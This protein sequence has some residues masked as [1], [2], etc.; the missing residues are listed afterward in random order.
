MSI[1]AQKLVNYAA[2]GI[3]NHQIAN[4]LGISEGRITQLLN[5]EKVANAIE[6]RKAAIAEE[7]VCEITDLK[8]VKRKII[9][10]LGELAENTES[11]SEAINALDKIDNITSR[12]IGS[13]DQSTGVKNIIIN[14]PQHVTQYVNDD[15]RVVTDSRNQITQIRGRSMAQMPTSG[16][17]QVLRNANE[18]SPSE[19]PAVTL[20]S[21]ITDDMLETEGAD[22]L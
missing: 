13:G 12:K 3:A 9:D 22:Q 2:H 10:R 6:K 17:I 19:D 1:D 5:A 15:A 20:I 7:A 8:S 18:D 4:A 11:L 21:D 16:V 14:I